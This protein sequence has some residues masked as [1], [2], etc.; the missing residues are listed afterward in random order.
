MRFL[1]ETYDGIVHYYKNIKRGF[2]LDFIVISQD[3]NQ[4]DGKQALR[5]YGK[6][7]A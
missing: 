2:P 4:A 5:E 7:R 6:Q 1:W 3:F